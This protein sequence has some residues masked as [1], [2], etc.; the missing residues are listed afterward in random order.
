M[1]ET[2]YQDGEC[3]LA[4]VL[5]EDGT[6]KKKRP[7]VLLHNEEDHTFY[8]CKATGNV[9]KPKN[10]RYGYEVKDWVDAGLHQPSII[11]CNQHEIYEVELEQFREKIGQL[12]HRDLRGLLT[13]QIKVRLLEKEKERVLHVAYEP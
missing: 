1:R 7:V 3:F 6:G 11:K 13:K 4:N 5:Y 9:T 12:S 2:D 8:A 10:Q